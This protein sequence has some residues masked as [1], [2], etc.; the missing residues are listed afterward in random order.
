[1]PRISGRNAAAMR[2]LCLRSP[3]NLKR[4]R[5]MKPIVL[6]N[7][8]AGTAAQFAGEDVASRVCQAFRSAGLE[9]EIV[10]VA[11]DGL[12]RA[13]DE[14]AAAKRPVIM[15]GGDGSVSAAVQRFAGTGIPLGVLPFGT[16]NLLAHDLGISTDLDEAARQ[17]AGAQERAIDLGRVGRRRFHTLG[18]L[19]FFSR[20]ARQRAE[21]RKTLPNRV[22]GAAVAAFRSLTTGG[23]LEIEIDD[24]SRRQS[25]RTPAVLITN[26]LLEPETWRR[27]RLDQG[28]FEINVVRG[29][30]QFPLLRG[31]LAAWMG[32]WRESGEIVSW[33]APR[34]TLTLRRPRVFL[35]LD[36][37]ITRPRTPLNFEIM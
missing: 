37:E 26:N 31:G 2:L 28:L 35:S 15:A 14:A 25:F 8:S 4:S 13:L 3:P 24:G 12:G 10:R 34:V 30:V 16:Y 19:G 17:L 11:P 29:D 5:P 1:M 33:S 7:A 21:I 23:N 27:R 22:I 18:G 36:G 32:S 20:V 9:A 6:V